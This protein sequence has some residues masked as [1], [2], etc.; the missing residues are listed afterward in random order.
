M[1]LSAQKPDIVA[2]LVAQKRYFATGR[3]RDIQFKLEQLE[4]LHRAIVINSEEIVRAIEA[5]SYKPE[6]EV[7]GGEW[8]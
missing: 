2:L 4:I 6:L 8:R 1:D 3:T 7:Y 5:D